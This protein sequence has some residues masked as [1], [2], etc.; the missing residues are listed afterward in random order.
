MYLGVF[1][2]P[3]IQLLWYSLRFLDLHV[4]FFHQMGKFSFIICSNKCSISWSSYSPSGSHMTRMLEHL[5]LSQMFLSFSSYF[6]ILVTSF[7]S[8]WIFIY[9]F[10]PQIVDLSPGFLPFTVGSLYI[11]LY[12]TLGSLHFFLHFLTKL[13]QFCEHPDYQCFELCIW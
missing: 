4:Y 2:P 9:S 11:L 3:W 5:K 1:V 12:L 13:S 6:W 7:C 8:G 10:F